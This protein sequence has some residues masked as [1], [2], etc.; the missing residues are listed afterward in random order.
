MRVFIINHFKEFNL[1][2]ITNKDI[3][4]SDLEYFM[5]LYTNNFEILNESSTSKFFKSLDGVSFIH[6]MHN[7][8]FITIVLKKN[9][10]EIK[11]LFNNKKNILNM[12][13]KKFTNIREAM[14]YISKLKRK[15]KIGF[16]L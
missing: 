1:N 4:E 3:R 2:F 11:V 7:D 13:D 15:Y 12:K 16:L 5:F 8:F 14:N 6:N 10:Y 9:L